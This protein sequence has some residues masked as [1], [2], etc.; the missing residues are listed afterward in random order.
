MADQLQKANCEIAGFARRISEALFGAAAHGWSAIEEQ[1][2]ALH[3][4]VARA[5]LSGWFDEVETCMVQYRAARKNPSD[6]RSKLWLEVASDLNINKAIMLREVLPKPATR[7]G[8]PRKSK[9]GQN[10][11]IFAEMTA[12]IELGDDPTPAAKRV[13]LARGVSQD[14]L[15]NKADYIVK[16]WKR[17]K[18]IA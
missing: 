15:K 16:L 18:K 17:R 9:I 13:L 14:Q 11:E 1:Q 12:L 5:K 4:L 2:R 6:P 10:V 8:R 3:A 7:L